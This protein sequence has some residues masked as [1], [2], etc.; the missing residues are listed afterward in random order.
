MS[1]KNRLVA[2][3]M[4]CREMGYQESKIMKF[5]QCLPIELFAHLI[6]SP[7]FYLRTQLST[8]KMT[9]QKIHANHNPE[10]K[11]KLKMSNFVYRISQKRKTL[12][13]NLLPLLEGVGVIGSQRCNQ[14]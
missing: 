14:L 9:K 4:F 3:R 7:T 2:E 1:T 11:H 10:G 13:I 5:T 6:F 8:Q 12:S